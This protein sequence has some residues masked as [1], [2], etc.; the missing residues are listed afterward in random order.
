MKFS[1]TITAGVAL[2][3]C[4]AVV[5]SAVE[6]YPEIN[7]DVKSIIDD[8]YDVTFDKSM[9]PKVR[10][11]QLRFRNYQIFMWIDTDRVSRRKHFFLTKFSICEKIGKNVT[12]V[13]KSVLTYT[14]WA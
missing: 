10:L 3:Q 12:G 13:Y 11:D 8:L 14:S 1:L 5:V 6:D 2:F 9:D 7:R 4:F